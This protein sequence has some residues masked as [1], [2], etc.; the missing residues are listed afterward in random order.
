MILIDSLENFVFTSTFFPCFVFFIAL[1]GLLSYI[2]LSIFDL[3]SYVIVYIFSVLVNHLNQDHADFEDIF[4]F[5]HLSST[6]KCFFAYFHHL[7]RMH[8]ISA[9]LYCFDKLLVVANSLSHSLP[10]SLL[11]PKVGKLLRSTRLFLTLTGNGASMCQLKS[12]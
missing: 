12:F 2:L 7:V 9:S 1:I 10:L 8:I 3:L 4:I 5:Y 6:K 11:M